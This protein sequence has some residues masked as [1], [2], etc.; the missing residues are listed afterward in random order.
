MVRPKHILVVRLSAM[1]DVAMTVPVLRVLLDTYPDLKITVVSRSFFKPFFQTLPEIEFLDA[2]IYG[3]H[4]GIPGLIKLAREANRLKIDAVA[5]LHQ[6]L[7]SRVMN[8]YFSLKSIPIAKIDKGRKDKKALVNANGAA[9][10]PLKTTH[11]RYADVFAELGFPI[12]LST[13]R[14]PN[15]PRMS[16]EVKSLLQPDKKYIGIAPFAAFKSKQ[17]PLEQ[18]EEV[19]HTLSKSGKYQLILFGGG[20]KEVQALDGLVNKYKNTISVAGK[21][22][23]EL[24]LNLI[25]QLN[26]MLSMD[27]GNGHLAA[28]FDVPVVT[29]WG[30]THPYAGFVPFGQ[31]DSNQLLADRSQYPLIPTSVYGNKMPEGYEK[32]METIPANSVIEK[33]VSLVNSTG[34]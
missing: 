13:H 19:L 17:Y 23:F 22:N 29:L 1:G 24:E 18:L 34:K 15:K 9:I 12:D 16:S 6:V 21:Y 7:R 10:K 4:K 32:V 27:S 25:A 30:N 5:D 11:Q 28:L 8:L 26:I 3:E 2:D 33:I 20:E 31:P 14:Y